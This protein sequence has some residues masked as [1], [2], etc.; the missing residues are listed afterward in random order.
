MAA[1]SADRTSSATYRFL[2]GELDGDTYWRSIALA[3]L[4]SMGVHPSLEQQSRINRGLNRLA[5][6]WRAA[7]LP[8]HPLPGERDFPIT[9]RLS[10]DLID[11][12]WYRSFEDELAR[13]R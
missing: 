11:A 12:A 9:H 13:K 3:R 4:I 6:S 7:K 2:S 1:D 10:S 8:T 5:A